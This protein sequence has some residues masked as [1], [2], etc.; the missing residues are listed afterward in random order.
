MST[1]VDRHDERAHR[2]QSAYAASSYDRRITYH[3]DAY[4]SEEADPY[5]GPT[6]EREY[7]AAEWAEYEFSEYHGGLEDEEGT[8]DEDE[9][10]TVEDLELQC[11][12]ACLENGFTE[13]QVSQVVQAEVVAFVAV[14]GAKGKSKGGKGSGKE[15]S[16]KSGKKNKGF[17]E[18]DI[19]E[20]DDSQASRD[21]R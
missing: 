12:K 20:E 5:P 6:P 11:F 8:E 7:T 16:G 9:P 17:R 21:L 4:Y 18:L 14:K 1:R 13:E 3:E 15:K 10:E 19:E 2:S